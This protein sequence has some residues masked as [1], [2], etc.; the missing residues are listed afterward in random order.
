MATPSRPPTAL[1]VPRKFAPPS[2]ARR[3]TAVL[4]LPMWLLQD[5]ENSII[6]AKILS[7][8]RAMRNEDTN[9]R[10]VKVAC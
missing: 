3:E 10:A 9:M 2:R 4:L 7:D 1:A 8:W 5:G 6:D